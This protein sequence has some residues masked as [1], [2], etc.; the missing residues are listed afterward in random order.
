MIIKYCN[1]RSMRGRS[2]MLLICRAQT[3]PPWLSETV[4]LSSPPLPWASRF[5]QLHMPCP[6]SAKRL[7][8]AEITGQ[9]LSSRA[10]AGCS[11]GQ[12]C[13]IDGYASNACVA[14][15]PGLGDGSQRQS[16]SNVPTTASG[17]GK[18]CLRNRIDTEFLP[19]MPELL[20]VGEAAVRHHPP[21]LSQ[22]F[23]REEQS[24]SA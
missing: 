16:V 2:Q 18:I 12:E 4:R 24:G 6:R 14:S 10:A 22:P 13:G 9:P 23:W 15:G 21:Q 17:F 19:N 5:A 1:I 11:Q 3:D 8:C 7:A 20:R